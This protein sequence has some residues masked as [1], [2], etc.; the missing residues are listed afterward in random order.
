MNI[1]VIS[2]MYPNSFNA[3]N[4][5]FVHKQLCALKK[6]YGDDVKV[7]VI[8]PVAYTPYVLSK[9]SSKYKGYYS[10]PKCTC[11][12][13]I[14]VYYPRVFML[15][16]NIGFKYSGNAFYFGI[17][18]VVKKLNEK[19]R[20]NL[21]HAHVALPDGYGALLLDKSLKIPL[22]ITIHGQDI[23]YTSE[24]GEAFKK[25]ISKAIN[26]ASAVVFVSNKLKNKCQDLYKPMNKFKV[27]NNG[28]D[29][30]I[31]LK[32][33][34][35]NE[36]REEYKGKRIILS[37]G[38]L[39]KPKGNDLTIKAFAKLSSKYDDIILLIIGKGEEYKNLKELCEKY[40]ISDKV[41]F[42][43]Q[44]PHEEVLHYMEICYMFVLP[45]WREGFGIVYIEA[46][47]RGKCV[48]GCKGEGIEDVIC[49]N[50][51][52]I[53]VKPKDADELEMKMDKLLSDADMV[54]NIG[55]KAK[56]KVLRE[57]TWYKNAEK[58]YKLY[59]EVLKG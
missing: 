13:G 30:D 21:I 9:L 44:L 26:V 45:S 5:I 58:L 4:G 14:D 16:K 1:L 41:K 56:S 31:N 10:I 51:D 34:R 48:I 32:E 19:E 22:I 53:L 59:L 40:N 50:V 55:N 27:I 2:H 36:L 11:I 57:F 37:V 8:S 29:V 43:N 47:S 54:K 17:R 46:M 28:V 52:G 12:D 33:D 18:K 24:L 20:F 49:D 3:M 6:L 23:D 35:L 25:R 42:L 38:N 15:P 39:L 7:K